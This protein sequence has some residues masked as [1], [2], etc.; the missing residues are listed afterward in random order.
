MAW[1][2]ATVIGKNHLGEAMDYSDYLRLR[3]VP[4]RVGGY[5]YAVPATGVV[6]FRLTY[7]SDEELHKIAPH[8]HRL[9]RN[10]RANVHRVKIRIV[11]EE[12]L[13]E[14]I[15]LARLAYDATF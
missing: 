2:G 15:R 14:A 9:T 1:T 5:A 8:A 11:D 6:E 10:H 13:D 7:G 3:R 4:S 12:T